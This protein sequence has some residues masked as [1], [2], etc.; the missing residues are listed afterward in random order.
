MPN[1]RQ[2]FHHGRP[3][4]AARDCAGKHRSYPV[5]R[6]FHVGLT[7]KGVGPPARLDRFAVWSAD[8]IS[9]NT[10]S[11]LDCS[12][13]SPQLRVTVATKSNAGQFTIVHRCS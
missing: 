12:L 8:P 13:R 3:E 1:D 6:L 9:R 4:R 10:V 2:R 11:L 7:S 5:H